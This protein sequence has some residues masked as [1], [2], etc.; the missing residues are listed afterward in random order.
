MTFRRNMRLSA[1]HERVD[2][3][4]HVHRRLGMV[5]VICVT[6]LNAS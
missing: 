5:I 6:Q 2:R 4:S 1:Q 3:A